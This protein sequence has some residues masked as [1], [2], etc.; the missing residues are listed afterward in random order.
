MLTP[1]KPNKQRSPQRVAPAVLTRLNQNQSDT[2]LS[3]QQPVRSDRYF[4]CPTLTPLWYTPGY[5]VL[6]EPD[7][8]L[9]NQ[10]T[11]LMSIE[12]IGWFEATLLPALTS[13]IKRIT[14]DEVESD[15]MEALKSFIADECQHI[16]WWEKLHADS[17]TALGL[18]TQT[19]VLRVNPLG[20]RAFHLIAGHACHVTAVFWVMLAL[21][22][23]GLEIARRTLA[24]PA[25]QIDPRHLDAHRHHVRDEARHVQL[26]RHLID[27]FYRRQSG[28][29]R[30]VNAYLFD[31]LLMRYLLPPVRGASQVVDQLARMRPPVR[32]HVLSLKQQLRT[33]AHHTGYREMMYSRQT[34]PV[35]F[36]MFDEHPQMANLARR[37][38]PSFDA[39]LKR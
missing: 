10:L 18:D 20:K 8:Q 4:L 23:H 1:V 37:L 15:L 27:C 25:D 11:A 32:P 9:Y 6:E 28:A 17:L 7:Q 5:Q 21:E 12:L 39:V 3:D 30:R 34:T 16:G 35:L 22:E 33:L 26:D 24:Q 36:S 13:A 29:A 38:E 31:R 14:H 19:R 2:P